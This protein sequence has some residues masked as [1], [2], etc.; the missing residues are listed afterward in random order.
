MNYYT[1]RIAALEDENT[2]LKN[3]LAALKEA[4]RWIP[5]GE[6][7]PE[8]VPPDYY[9]LWYTVCDNGGHRWS[10]KWLPRREFVNID[11]EADIY[12]WLPL[13]VAPEVEK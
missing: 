1:S 6:R 13:P 4:N 8:D 10:A 7:M 9:F 3:E 5:V 2:E 12:C 11:G